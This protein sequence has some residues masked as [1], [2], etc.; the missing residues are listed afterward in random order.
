MLRQSRRTAK[1]WQTGLFRNE[2][3]RKVRTV[4]SFA[5]TGTLRAVLAAIIGMSLSVAPAVGGD[6]TGI[7]KRGEKIG[8]SPKVAMA[9]VMKT[10]EKFFDKTV[11]L[12]G[13]VAEVCQKKGCWM[14]VLPGSDST[15]V[16]VTF[17]DYGFF[18]P[19]DCHG[20]AVLIEG[21]FEKKVL[22]KDDADHMEAEGANIVRNADGTATEI[23]F[24]AT[25][26]ELRPKKEKADKKSKKS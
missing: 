4:K 7:I 3:A 2:P 15:S 23:G 6:D 21:K 22:S 17:K 18:V 11:A 24:V 10:P 19:K 12:E 25:G 16:R 14:E 20:M 9:D 1:V 13:T 5:G 26:V 8:K